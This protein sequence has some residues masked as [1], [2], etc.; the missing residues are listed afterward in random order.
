MNNEMMNNEMRRAERAMGAE[1]TDQLLRDGQFGVLC[2]GGGAG[3]PYG[4]PLSYVFRDGIIYFHCA[5]GAGVKLALL[6]ENPR[7]CFTVV[8][9]AL[10]QPLP[11]QFSLRYRSVMAFGTAYVA[12]GSERED[13]LLALAEKYAPGRRE[14]AE[15]YIRRSAGAVSVYGIRLE[16]RTGKAR[17]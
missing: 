17:R 5:T 2:V 6:K 12:A 11:D 9:T 1:E 4:V 13:A 16:R 7:V 8:D 15:A 10:L 14:R 3:I